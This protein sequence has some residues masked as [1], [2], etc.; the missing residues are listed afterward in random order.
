V[1]WQV[2]ARRFQR[3]VR[4]AYKP[5]ARDRK[6]LVAAIQMIKGLEIAPAHRH[7]L[8][9]LDLWDRFQYAAYWWMHAMIAVWL[10]FSPLLRDALGRRVRW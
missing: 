10:P 8:S 1:L 3:H 2:P 7:T 6:T 5:K 9:R 4:G